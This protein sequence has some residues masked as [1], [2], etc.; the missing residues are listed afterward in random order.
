MT[1]ILSVETAVP[2][3]CVP[4]EVAR[5][6]VEKHFAAQFPD[7]GRLL[8]VFDN[9]QVD[10]RYFSAP[11]EWFEEPRSFAERNDRYVSSAISLG[12][13]VIRRCVQAAGL[14]LQDVDHLIFVSSTGFS[15]PSIDAHLINRLN[16][17]RDIR[18]TPIW[19]LG[20]GGGVAG[21]ARAYDFVRAYPEKR[22]LIVALELCGLTFQRNDFSK[23]N[24][25]ATCLFGEGAGGVLVGRAD[26]G[27]RQPRILAH[28]S[29][30]WPDSLD[31]MGWRFSDEGLEVIFSRDIP[32]IVNQQFGPVVR[33]FLAQFGLEPGQVRHYITHP[34]G[35]KVIDAYES[36]LNVPSDRM[37]HAR[38]VLRRYG[39]MSSPSVLFVLR[40]FLNHPEEIH[41]GDHGL[42]SA[43]GPGFSGELILLRW[44]EA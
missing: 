36:A 38:E 44:D 22:A 18:R 13:Q 11:R 10:T 25:I 5:R 6:F 19:G 40:E 7:L 42:M 43:L 1:N 4:Q 39:N 23:S 14:S 33:D 35:A 21:L 24:L 3:Y 2:P 41:P 9:V 28:Q 31:V 30:L 8:A 26:N 12:E 17:R 32:T 27:A 37:R 15:T 20:C 29:I 34:G 16:L